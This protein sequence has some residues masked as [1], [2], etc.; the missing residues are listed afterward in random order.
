M[1]ANHGPLDRSIQHSTVCPVAK[2]GCWLER[3]GVLTAFLTQ[4]FLL[5]V[6]LAGADPIVSQGVPTV[7]TLVNFKPQL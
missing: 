3:A 6:A 2:T 4:C 1:M 5:R 7:Q